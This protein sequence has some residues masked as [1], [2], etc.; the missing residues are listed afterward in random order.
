MQ[1]WLQNIKM[2]LLMTLLV[3]IVYPILVLVMA[4]LFMPKKAQGSFVQIG[5]KNVGSMLVGQRFQTDRYF[6]GRPSAVDYNTLPAGA[7]NLS[8]TSAK[9]R[10]MISQ[11]RLKIAQA[12]QTQNLLMVPAE[13]VCASASGIDPH[14]SANTAFFQMDRVLQAPSMTGEKSRS[15]LQKMIK[16]LIEYPAGRLISIPRLNVLMLNLALDELEDSNKETYE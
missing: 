16:D 12:H 11:R 1:N 7:S 10:N 5:E 2:L 6:W 13:L 8:P 3:G 9:L 4:N 15:I 14:I